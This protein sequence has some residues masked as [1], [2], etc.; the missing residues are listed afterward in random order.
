MFF[1]TKAVD[2]KVRALI[3]RDKLPGVSISI[4][5]PE[6]PVFEKGY[7][8]RDG[9][10]TIPVDPDTMFGIAS[11]SKSITA[12]ALAIIETE[13]KLSYDDPV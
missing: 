4:L 13:G 11:M 6:G 12:L 5:G 9:K 1:D 2:E 3:T 8:W 7:G 10:S